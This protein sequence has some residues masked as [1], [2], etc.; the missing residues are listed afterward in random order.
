MVNKAEGRSTL[1]LF[2]HHFGLKNSEIKAQVVIGDN[3]QGIKTVAG[4]VNA[5]PM[6]LLVQQSMK[7]STERLLNNSICQVFLLLLPLFVRVNTPC[8]GH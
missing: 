8:H 4:N 6:F 5:M 1:E 3:Q 7:S 2:L